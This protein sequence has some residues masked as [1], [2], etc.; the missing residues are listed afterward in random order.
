MTLPNPIRKLDPTVV[1]RIAAGEVIQRPANALKEMLEN[2]LDANATNIQITAKNGGMKLLQ[3]VDNGCGIRKED[4]EIV[5]ERFTTSKLRNF[6]DLTSIT[7]YGFRGEGL[8]S[9]SHV[10]HLTI[11]TK[12]A[13]SQCAFRVSYLDG[14][15]KSAPKP[16]AGNQGTQIIV[17]DLFYNLATRRKALKTTYE[18]YAKIADVVG[19]YAIHNSH[20]G[21]SLKKIGESSACIRTQ[22]NS[23][24]VD[25]ICNIF[26]NSVARELLDVELQSDSL[27]FKMHGHITNANYS[28]RKLLF[29]LFINNRLVD[30]VGIRKVVDQVYSSY[31]PKG[32]HPFIYL[33]LEIN[34]NNVDVNVH[35]TKHQV[36]FL[37]EEEITEKIRE[38]IEMRLVNC[39]TSRVF[40]TQAHL[41]GSALPE[42]RPETSTASPSQV[43]RTDAAQQKMERFLSPHAPPAASNSLESSK[44]TSEGSSSTDID[45]ERTRKSGWKETNLH[46]VL[47]LRAAI[48]KECHAGLRLLFKEHSFVGCVSRSRALVQHST[49]LYLCNTRQLCEELFYQI[50]MYQF[51]NFGMIKF[52]E[53]L[54]LQDLG[55]LALKSRWSGWTEADGSQDSLSK[56]IASFLAS[57][58]AMLLDYFSIGIEPDGALLTGI[59]I[60]IDGFFP[61]SEDLPRWV[62]R[63]ATEVEWG[64]EKL[65]FETL[66]RETARFYAMSLDQGEED[67]EKGDEPVERAVVD[68][69]SDS[70]EASW[71][72]VV[73]H[74]VYTALRKTLLPPKGFSTDGCVLQVA[75]LPDLY[76]VFERC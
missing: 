60:L 57:K 17:E 9:I 55:L 26:G 45:E 64:D 20:V 47:S 69:Q 6:E 62:L 30:S 31:L 27:G 66:C 52:S 1:N 25:N 56:F 41:P 5:C 76:K 39:N 72:H 63:L 10:A 38:A 34:P 59:P 65:C 15:M 33:S 29:L 44:R 48:E 2:C 7:T 74:K 40:Y 3:I 49:S 36:H 50:M 8:A 51:G 18:E 73:E 32:G 22:P 58:S 43:V 28:T 67:E 46:S 37:H 53:A 54:P 23:T 14:K 19:S 13:D 70:E 4:L 42:R 75:H 68:G 21:F 71:R 11:I 12:T 61:R 35:P 16:C 24:R